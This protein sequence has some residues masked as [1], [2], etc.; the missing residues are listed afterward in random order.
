MAF[1]YAT[2]L[3]GDL[4]THFGAGEPVV[5][6]DLVERALDT[7]SVFR[8]TSSLAATTVTLRK[9]SELEPK[10]LAIMHGSSYRG[11]GGGALRAL[12]DG[13]EKRFAP[14]T[15]FAVTRGALSV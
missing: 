7:E 2:L 11:D 14:E 13:Y 3:S 15:D 8:A 1:G 5:G 9:L 12:A 6:D 4:F 10:T